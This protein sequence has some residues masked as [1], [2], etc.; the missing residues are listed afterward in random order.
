MPG[1]IQHVEASGGDVFI[2]IIQY[3]VTALAITRGGR[4]HSRP[5][6]NMWCHRRD[7]FPPGTPDIQQH[8]CF[9]AFHA[10]FLWCS[11]RCSVSE[12]HVSAHPCLSVTFSNNSLHN[13][14]VYFLKNSFKVS[15]FFLQ[16]HLFACS[17]IRIRNT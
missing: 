11:S 13:S 17:Q 16:I 12:E 4:Y 15:F 2:P 5:V 7:G 3:M 14:L 10:L 1:T 9:L 6:Y 8:H